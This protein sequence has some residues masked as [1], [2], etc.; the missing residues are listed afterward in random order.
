MIKDNPREGLTF[1]DVLLKPS[2]SD[3]LP[4]EVD[5]RSRVTRN[6]KLNIPIIAS[7]MDTV[8]EAHMAIAMAQAGGIGVVHR[9]LEPAVQA[10]QVRQVKKF[11]SGMVVN[12]VTVHPDATLADALELLQEH[13]I[14]GIPVVEGG[15]NGRAGKLVGILTNRDVR[16]ATD[17]QQ[18]VSDLMTKEGLVTVRESVEQR[19]AKRLLHQHR[20]EKLLVVDGDF[21]CVGL[22]TVKDIEKA[23]ANPNACKDE[24]GR[25]RVAAAT[26]VGDAGYARSEKLIEAGVDLVVVDTAHGHSRRVLDAVSRIKRLSNAVQVVAGNIATAEGAKALIDAGAD[27]IKVGIG[28]G[29]I[30]TTRIVAGVGVPQLTAI[31]D[32]VEVAKQTD[33]P[34]IADGGI[35]YSGDLAKAVAAGA[36]CAMVG[37]LLAGTDETPGEVFL[38]QG[39]TYKT[40]RGMGS[41]AAMARGSADR[42]FQQEIKDTLKLVPEG[43]EGQV[44][45]KGP[46]ANVLHQ[47]AGGLR[48]AMGYVGARNIG[49]LQEKAEFIRV[50]G[51][52]L[53]ES[54]V[55]DVTITRESPNYPARE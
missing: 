51:A 20:I 16:F 19:E 40:Y 43:V 13:H 47:L 34:V 49:E 38:Y 18:K 35:K 24:Q 55:H 10:A 29:S 30:C 45:Y 12:P 31:M 53:R 22:I 36:E 15:G 6:I 54:H 21:R 48:A 23:V 50:S 37:S 33:T 9:N 17:K 42:Y 46:A 1:D 25:L 44:P 4:S 8:T 27:A 39:R 28:P 11:E 7:A 52:G 5:I 41:V 2:L 26:T 14:S 32:T 3:V